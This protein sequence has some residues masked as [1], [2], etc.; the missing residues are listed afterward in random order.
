VVGH[1]LADKRTIKH[2]IASLQAVKTWQLLVV[3]ILLGFVA[4]TF[5]RMNNTGMIARRDAVIAADK[6]GDT[7]AIETRLHELQVYS[8]SRMNADTGVFYLQEQYN[9]DVQKAVEI[10]SNQSSVAADA[11]AK[12]EA[13]CHPQYSG[14][15]TAYMNC[16][17]S[18]LAKY[19]T[20]DA[21]P[22][23]ELPSS[24]LYRYS[25]ASP[26]WSPDFAGWTI[27]LCLVVVFL[28]IMRLA[29]LL[30]LRLMLR[31]HY[32]EV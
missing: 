11:N 10:S 5:L 18:E 13:V 30:F 2:G 3:L 28:I 9:R 32:R 23:P 4:A 1:V 20:A 8:S 25:F 24:S 27:A 29:G 17:L 7:S 22:E 6:A 26:L 14:W 12:A 15:S 19:P 16:F 21:L 31:H